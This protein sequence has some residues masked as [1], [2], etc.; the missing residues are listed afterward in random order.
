MRQS[1]LLLMMFLS[2]GLFAAEKF[3][4]NVLRSGVNV[5]PDY[6]IIITSEN[7]PDYI[8]ISLSPGRF[9][10]PGEKLKVTITDKCENLVFYNEFHSSSVRIYKSDFSG[11]SCLAEINGDQEYNV[12][13]DYDLNI[14]Y[15]NK[16]EIEVI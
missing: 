11:V 1:I 12:C 13:A 10:F 4:E 8:D 3:T 2:F 5:P 15:L 6:Q 14:G 16:C 7:G 9:L